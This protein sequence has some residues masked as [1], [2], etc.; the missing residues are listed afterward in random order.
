M[1]RTESNEYESVDMGQERP[2]A[3]RRVSVRWIEIAGVGGLAVG[4]L[5][6]S[7][8]GR[9]VDRIGI[10]WQKSGHDAIGAGTAS[11]TPHLVEQYRQ[12]LIRLTQT[13]NEDAAVLREKQLTLQILKA[14]GVDSD[15]PS[16]RRLE[17]EASDLQ[18][19]MA[20]TDD[21]LARLREQLSKLTAV[22]SAAEHQ[23]GRLDV[24]TEVNAR[25]IVLEHD[26]GLPLE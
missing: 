16:S 24:Q 19:T 5:A 3:R 15:S 25:R 13:R 23:D 21:R 18:A 26:V 14:R 10:G 8:I 17:R 12:E 22:K 20:G 4:F 11:P 2:T 1:K 6:G 9:L 7:Q